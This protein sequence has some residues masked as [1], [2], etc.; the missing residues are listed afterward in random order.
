MKMPK[1]ILAGAGE[2]TQY[3]AHDF[4]DNTV[5]FAICYPG[6]LSSEILCSAVAAVVNSVEV[7][8]ASFIPGNLGAHWSVNEDF[9]EEEDALLIQSMLD[10]IVREIETYALDI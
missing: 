6:R 2:K 4:N 3:L 7:L 10:G 9:R 8:H 5:R 1:V